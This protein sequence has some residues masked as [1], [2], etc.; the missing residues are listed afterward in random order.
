[1]RGIGERGEE[2]PATRT[3]LASFPGSLGNANF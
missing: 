1:M 2:T 3:A